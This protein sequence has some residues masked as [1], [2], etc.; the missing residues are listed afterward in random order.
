MILQSPKILSISGP[1]HIDHSS[2][3]VQAA[4][5]DLSSP[6]ASLQFTWISRLEHIKQLCRLQ[7]H[8]YA[9]RLTLGCLPYTCAKS[10]R[11]AE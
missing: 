4:D 2:V 8:K 9:G 1:Q 6:Q 3:F 10:M 5:L 11:A 7:L